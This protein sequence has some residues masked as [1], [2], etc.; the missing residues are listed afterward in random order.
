M[1][2]EARERLHAGNADGTIVL[3]EEARQADPDNL[4]VGRYR[5]RMAE[6]WG[7]FTQLKRIFR[8]QPFFG[9]RQDTI[10]CLRNRIEK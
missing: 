7:Q 5:S 1:V 2:L 3:F 4:P 9:W 10:C 6:I 8:V